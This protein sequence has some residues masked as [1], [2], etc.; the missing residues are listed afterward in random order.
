MANIFISYNRQIEAIAKTLANDFE[1]LG[2]TVWFDQEISGGQAWWDQILATVRRCDLFVFLLEPEALNSTACK[3]EYSYAADLGKPI[4][5]VLVSDGVP[6]NLLPP[7]LS[8]IQFVDYRTQDRNA[9]FRLARALNT[10]PPPDPLP[11]PLPAPPEAPISYLGSLTSQVETTSILTYEQQTALVFDLK[12]GLRDHGTT[13]DTRTLLERLRKRRDLFATIAEEIDELL[14]SIRKAA[15]APLRA[16]EIIRPFSEQSQN[17]DTPSV[18]SEIK[19]PERQNPQHSATQ[20]APTRTH[21]KPT[22]RE[23]VAG[24]CILAFIGLAA[25]LLI[26]G[27][28][29]DGKLVLYSQ[30]ERIWYFF[31]LGGAIAGA[32]SGMGRLGIVA[33]VVGLCVA[34]ALSF[35]NLGMV[36]AILLAILP[37]PLCALVG[38]YIKKRKGQT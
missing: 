30:G 10:I 11:D 13:D 6:T 32:I 15:A 27:I 8:Q 17:E 2:H 3:R 7:A 31:P 24:A 1:S 19:P 9:A 4:L 5:P 37:S 25:G 22:R 26:M 38:V 12:R 16:S 14:G 34:V 18:L 20:P 35:L 33:A 36:E 29:R 23:R 28:Y 21:H